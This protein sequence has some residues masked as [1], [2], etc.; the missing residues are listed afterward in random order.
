MS[1]LSEGQQRLESLVRQV[2]RAVATS[3]GHGSKATSAGSCPP[4]SYQPPV[5]EESLCLVSHAPSMLSRD[6][7][8]PSVTMSEI[9]MEALGS[10][11]SRPGRSSR[12]ANSQSL[13]NESLIK[14]RDGYYI[15]RPSVFLRQ[16]TL[17]MDVSTRITGP[18]TDG[19]RVFFLHPD[20]N[21]RT[22]FDLVSMCLLLYDSVVIPYQIAW[23]PPFRGWMPVVAWAMLFFWTLDLMLGFVTGYRLD[24]RLVTDFRHIARRYLTT[25]FLPNLLVVISDLVA[26][27]VM[28]G[29][30]GMLA[31]VMRSVRI[32]KLSR[33]L[34]LAMMMRTGQLAH[35]YDRLV[36]ATR[37]IGVSQHLD[38]SMSIFKLVTLI[39]W[40]NHFSCCMWHVVGQSASENWFEDNASDRDFYFDYLLGFYWATCSMIAGESVMTPTNKMELVCTI[41]LIHFGF[42]FGS[43]IISSLATSLIDFQMSNK[44]RRERVKSLR[45]F[46]YQHQVDSKLCMPIEKQVLNRMSIVKR[47]TEKDVS[48]L[49][50]LSPQL[51]AELCYTI[52]GSSVTCHAF[53]RTCN[54]MNPA[55]IQDVCFRAL[56]RGIYKPGEKVFEAN[57]EAEGAHFTWSGTLEYL[58]IDACNHRDTSQM[59]TLLVLPAKHAD[60]G[61]WVCELALWAPWRHRGWLEAS[62]PAEVL[63]MKVEPLLKV[64]HRH[65]EVAYVV[66]DY[67][68]ALCAVVSQEPLEALS[69]LALEVEHEQIVTAMPRESRNLMSSAAIL[70]LVQHSQWASRIFEKKGMQDLAEEVK[71]GECDVV[72]CASDRVLR[73]VSVVGLCLRREDGQKLVQIGKCRGGVASPGCVLPGTKVRVGESPLDALQ[74]VLKKQLALPDPDVNIRNIKKREVV[75]E[76]TVSKTYGVNTKYMRTIFDAELVSDLEWPPNRVGRRHTSASSTMAAMAYEA[77][78]LLENGKTDK[79]LLVAWMP[80]DD[81]KEL[82]SSHAGEARVQKWVAE[83]A[84]AT[85]EVSPRA[86]RGQTG[87][88]TGCGGCGGGNGA[89]ADLCEPPPSSGGPDG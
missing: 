63:T 59:H 57:M 40:V 26:I 88:A 47:I 27:L 76:E 80:D 25:F 6:T 56:V 72:L 51:R 85:R 84:P 9:P 55:F 65:P 32:I 60:Q 12:L 89:P 46:L 38:V 35:L 21:R 73:L 5:E 7:H 69:D 87:L 75:T 77:F 3:P 29:G 74:R 11:D 41:F 39:L 82:S 31:T 67:S 14:P 83:L 28:A 37:K 1:L 53:F 15:S 70:A 61:S 17:F 36:V 13:Q 8:R 22:A 33:V 10:L 16:N 19:P 18:I 81:F 50:L 86:G 44:E 42:I 20:S 48:A 58:P 54:A 34:R 79:C 43:V 64:L 62:T 4:M 45:Q 30:G 23:D 49:S 2:H 52:Y 66:Q 24:D 68:A 71:S 78:A